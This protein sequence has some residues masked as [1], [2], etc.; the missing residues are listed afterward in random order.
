MTEIHIS[1]LWSISILT[2]IMGIQKVSE[3]L[4]LNS[5]LTHLTAQEDLSACI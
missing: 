5:N 4:V 2:L 3:T 1:N